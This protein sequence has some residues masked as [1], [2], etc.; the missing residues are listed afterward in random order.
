ME[1]GGRKN[2]YTKKRVLSEIGSRQT[3]DR[4]RVVEKVQ[5]V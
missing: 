4:G 5:S 3:E 2:E 1:G